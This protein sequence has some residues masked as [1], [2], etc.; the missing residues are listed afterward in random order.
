MTPC[1]EKKWG[2]CLAS[3][4]QWFFRRP[5][6]KKNHRQLGS[7]G[8]IFGG[9]NIEAI[10]SNLKPPEYQISIVNITPVIMFICFYTSKQCIIMEI[11]IHFIIKFDPFEKNRWHSHSLKLSPWKLAMPKGNYCWWKNPCTS[12]HVWNPVNYGISTI[13]TGVGF[14]PSTTIFQP[15]IL[16]VLIML[17]SEGTLKTLVSVSSSQYKWLTFPRLPI[18]RFFWASPTTKDFAN[19]PRCEV[20]TAVVFFVSRRPNGR[21]RRNGEHVEINY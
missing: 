11:L 15:S 16:Q 19:T 9:K 14:Q 13:S 18:D 7:F 4:S 20:R 1:F 21:R 3:W 8:S 6:E 10:I 12:Q 17:A 2:F 5:L